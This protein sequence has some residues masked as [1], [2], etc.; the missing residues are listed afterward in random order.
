MRVRVENQ[1]E[2]D[3]QKAIKVNA[4]KGAADGSN[5]ETRAIGTFGRLQVSRV[6][7]RKNPAGC[8]GHAQSDIQNVYSPTVSVQVGA[9]PNG[10]EHMLGKASVPV[11]ATRQSE[12]AFSAQRRTRVKTAGDRN[13]LKNMYP[14]TQNQP[15]ASIQDEN[16]WDLAVNTLVICRQ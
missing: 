5:T 7:S 1:Q 14:R 13:L 8:P 12:H 15:I 2:H 10:H 3:K 4:R 6:L 11:E 16:H 9:M